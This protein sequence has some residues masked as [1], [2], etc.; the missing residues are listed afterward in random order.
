M[1]LSRSVVLV[2]P[3][4]QVLCRVLTRGSPKRLKEIIKTAWDNGI[5]MIDCAESYSGGENEISVYVSSSFWTRSLRVVADTG[6]PR[7]AGG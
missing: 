3:I 4:L 1:T 7:S 5:N 6:S 2:L